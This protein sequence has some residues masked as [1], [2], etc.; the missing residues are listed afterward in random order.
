M[1]L[2]DIA[3][4]PSF[5]QMLVQVLAFAGVSASV[6]VLVQAIFL[7][8]SWLGGVKSLRLAAQGTGRVVSSASRLRPVRGLASVLITLLVP[9]GQLL[10]LGLCYL[11]G[12]YVAM[13]FDDERWQQMVHAIEGSQVLMTTAEDPLRILSIGYL[14]EIRRT[15]GPVLQ[16]DRV[17]ATY[18]GLSALLMVMSYFW[19]GR[20]S[21]K[22]HTAGVLV[23]LPAVVLL[24]LGGAGAVLYGLVAILNIGIVILSL[25]FGV[26]A[27]VTQT[28]VEIA[29][30]SLP[31]VAGLTI[32]A[33]YYAACQ[34]AV[35]NSR[36]VV[37]AWRSRRVG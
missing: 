7:V 8:S 36:L 27:S 17:A 10:A 19:A 32:C 25:L 21:D 28:L 11:G 34:G 37:E 18:V 6:L 12:N 30:T 33:I 5:D 16:L 24:V 29:L 35:Q 1:T 20:R 2:P 4:I 31:L 22:L 3:S 9:L 26:E 23:A 14:Q 13:I 15:V